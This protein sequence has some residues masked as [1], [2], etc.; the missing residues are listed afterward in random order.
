MNL[1]KPWQEEV[2]EGLYEC[3]ECMVPDESEQVEIHR[4]IISFNWATGTFGKT[5][6]KKARDEDQP[7]KQFQISKNQKFD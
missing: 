3:L 4:Q 2:K 6:A 5:L 7:G 1:D